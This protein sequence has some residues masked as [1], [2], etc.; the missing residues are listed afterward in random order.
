MGCDWKVIRT[1]RQLRF[2]LE[3]VDVRDEGFH[4]WSRKAILRKLFGAAQPCSVRGFSTP[5]P[6]AVLLAPGVRHAC[7]PVRVH[8]GVSLVSFPSPSAP[9]GLEAE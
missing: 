2:L 1:S 3:K 9:T 4:G 5:P 7:R 8:V 6:P